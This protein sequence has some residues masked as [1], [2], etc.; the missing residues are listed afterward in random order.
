MIIVNPHLV[1]ARIEEG[2]VLA[3]VSKEGWSVGGAGG[4]LFRVTKAF[5]QPLPTP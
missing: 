3:A 5:Y 4:I 1:A 2:S